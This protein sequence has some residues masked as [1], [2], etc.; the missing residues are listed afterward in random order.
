MVLLATKHLALRL[1]V[2]SYSALPQNVLIVHVVGVQQ[3]WNTVFRFRTDSIQLDQ[4]RLVGVILQRLE[5]EVN[6]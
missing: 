1:L 3:T 6:V 2:S 5:S 4:I